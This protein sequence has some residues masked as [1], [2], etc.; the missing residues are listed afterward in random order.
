MLHSKEFQEFV[1]MAVAAAVG[2]YVRL[3]A[4]KPQDAS[5]ERAELWV[6]IISQWDR[7]DP[8]RG[9][10]E[11]F[12]NQIA[13]TR[14][15]SS[16]RKARAE[17]RSL[18]VVPIGQRD[19]GRDFRFPPPPDPVAALDLRIDVQAV[20]DR[21]PAYERA[22]CEELKTKALKPV[23]ESLGVPRSTVRGHTA[24]IRVQFEVAG[25]GEYGARAATS[26]PK[27][28]DIT[29]GPTMPPEPT[30]SQQLR[31]FA[32][33]AGVDMRAVRSL[34]EDAVLVAEW[35]HGG[36]AVRVDGGLRIDDEAGWVTISAASEVGAHLA[37]VFSGLCETELGAA[38]FSVEPA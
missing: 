22:L 6:A 21:M 23:A 36:P 13:K 31:R 5:D 1:E 33:P 3:G 16:L 8:A 35:V 7:Y 30:P 15:V 9:A 27:C 29:R 38:S 26:S 10:P 12:V 24:S 2:K 11:A 19:I 4:I 32:F 17:K 20:L 14:I 37:K 18:K 28:V 25:L 34:V